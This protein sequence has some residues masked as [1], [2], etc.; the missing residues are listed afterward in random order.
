[1]KKEVLTENEAR[2]YTVEMIL[3]VDSVHKLNCIARDLKQD[4]ILIYKN[5]HIQLSDFGLAKIADKSFFPITQIDNIGQQK[6]V[7][8]VLGSVTSGQY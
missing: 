1:M 3:A 5:E 7:N 2:F 6:V 4:N 8:D